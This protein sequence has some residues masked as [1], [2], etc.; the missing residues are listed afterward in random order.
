MSAKFTRLVR[1]EDSS[2]NVHYGE[3]GSDWQK[4]L[5]GQSVPT[6]NI[7]D[8]FAGEFPLTGNRV[9]IA[10]ALFSHRDTANFWS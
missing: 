10:K 3:A 6:Y 1:F 2:G 5:V 7:S 9:E 8:V 4:G